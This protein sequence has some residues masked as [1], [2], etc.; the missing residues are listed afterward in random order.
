MKSADSGK[1]A[2]QAY[3]R[4]RSHS[5]TAGLSAV[6]ETATEFRENRV[7]A[8]LKWVE[9]DSLD[10]LAGVLSLAA[11]EAGDDSVETLVSRWAADVCKSLAVLHSQ[12][13]VHGD[14]SP[15]NLIH[16]RGGLT[17]TDYDLVTPIGKSA[18]GVGAVLYCSPEA[19]EKSRSNLQTTC[20]RSRRPFLKSR[21]TI[22]LSVLLTEPLTNFTGSTG[23]PVTSIHFRSSQNS[24]TEQLPPTDRAAL[25]TVRKRSRSLTHWPSL[26][27]KSQ[28]RA[29]RVL[30]PPWYNA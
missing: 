12:G 19:Q 10:S 23:V 21:W 5:A 17:L 20:S 3:Q 25:R 29:R 8:L 4:V 7:V 16:H 30:N 22:E 9:G 14:I 15:R 1:A 6:F 11:E 28:R 27:R 26:K 13:L 2:L 18:W 24:W